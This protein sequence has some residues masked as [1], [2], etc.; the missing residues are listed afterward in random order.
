[1]PRA[2]IAH[3]R[4]GG[5]M[6]S[7]RTSS[8]DDVAAYQRL[9]RVVAGSFYDPEEALVIEA[10]LAAPRF[11]DAH[12]REHSALQLDDDI[13]ATLRLSAKQTRQA[14]QRLESDRLVLRYNTAIEDDTPA[15]DKAHKD[16]QPITADALKVFWG[17]DY[18]EMSDAVQYKVVAIERALASRAEAADAVPKY[19]C[20]RC[21]R[22]V[23]Y[24]EISEQFFGGD[25]LR[26]ATWEPT[27]R[28]V[29]RRGTAEHAPCAAPAGAPRVIASSR[30]SAARTIR[31][32]RA[33]EHRR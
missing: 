10:I 6:M 31:A 12:G 20:K 22:V 15:W 27:T 3:A 29:A 26:C 9:A 25:A 28:S 32:R 33:C 5:T 11:A 8:D 1:M 13:A 24:F 4:S 19:T 30:R 23:D 16:Q 18:E 14:L 7:Q 17:L 2:E 21:N